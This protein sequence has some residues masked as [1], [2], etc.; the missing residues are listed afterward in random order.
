MCTRLAILAVT[1][2]LKLL[3]RVVGMA[4]PHVQGRRQWKLA[5]LARTETCQGRLPD[6]ESP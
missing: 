5:I 1:R 6:P 2:A 3:I 4:A